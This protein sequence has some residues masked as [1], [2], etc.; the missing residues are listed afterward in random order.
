VT[1]ICTS[2][3]I[4]QDIDQ[5]S[6]RT[7]SKNGISTRCKTCNKNYL[8]NHYSENKKYYYNKKKKFQCNGKEFIWSFLKLKKCSDCGE[9]NPLL[10]EFDHI[11]DKSHNISAMIRSHSPDSVLKEIEKCE[12]VCA[13]CHRLRTYERTNTWYFQQWKLEY[14]Q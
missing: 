11:D 6:K 13:N 1:K 12:V 8:K 14:P 3:K 2:C 5:F 10:L 4:E 9:S 7:A